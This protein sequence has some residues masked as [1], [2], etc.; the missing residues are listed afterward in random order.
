MTSVHGTAIGELE[1]VRAALADEYEIVRELGRGG[2]AVVYRAREIQLGRDVAI[3]VLPPAAAADASFVERF[4]REARTAAR[5]EHPHIVPIHRV[6]RR[7][8]VIYLVMKLLGGPSLSDHLLAEGA[9]GAAAVRRLLL[10]TASALGHAHRHGVIHRDIKPDNVMLD[11]G[12]CVLTDFG[13]ARSVADVKLT[14]TGTT[15]GT[16]LYMSPEQGRG[17]GVDARSDIYS[18]GVVAYECLTGSPPFHG[19]N[20]VAVMMQHVQTPV[21]EPRLAGDE[22]RALWAVIARMLAKS[23]D[24]RFQSADDLIAALGERDAAATTILVPPSGATA[25]QRLVATWRPRVTSAVALLR[26]R[27]PRLDRRLV[28]RSAVAAAAC[29]GGYYGLHFAI[30]HRSRCAPAA[31]SAAPAAAAAPSAS[32]S[33][34]R[35]FAVMM[36]AVNTISAGGSVDVYYDVCGLEKGIPLTTRIAVAKNESGLR[37]LFG[38]VAPVIVT[39]DETARGPATRRHRTLDLGALPAGSYTLALTVS[40]D[41][42]RRRERSID[43]RIAPR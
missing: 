33:A 15:I 32:P 5:L 1:R 17:A 38:S 37:R 40:D 3:K 36:D 25:T 23:P 2:M 35:S 28:V 21:P 26:D 16:P 30:K 20:A 42:G 24:A 7:D 11:D 41:Q 12:R 22:E 18:L 8:D 43:F 31:P 34:T 6:G 9:L 4:Q 14:A 19:D 13:I 39:Y 29:V 10:E 27:L